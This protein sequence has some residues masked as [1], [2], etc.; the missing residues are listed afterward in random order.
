M[1]GFLLHCINLFSIYSVSK[2]IYRGIC[3]SPIGELIVESDGI[4]IVS[5]LFKNDDS[6]IE[7]N[8]DDFVTLCINQLNEYFNGE[9]KNFDLPLNPKGT[10]FQHKVWDEVYEIPFGETTSYGG[11]AIA[12][13]D[14]KLNRAVGLANGAN[15]IPIVIPCHRVIGGDGSL[16]GYAGGL[17]RKKWLLNHEAKFHSITKGQLKL[18]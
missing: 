3:N 12:L 2:N 13:G 16:T 1:R 17:E 4:S 18:F 14:L 6:I 5:I 10:E 11:I 8:P 15:P 9:R 7:Q